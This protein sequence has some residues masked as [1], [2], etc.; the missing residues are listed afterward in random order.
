MTN[1]EDLEVKE[2]KDGRGGA[3]PGAGRKTNASK[4]LPPARQKCSPT[5]FPGTKDLAIL[6]AEME[7]FRGWGH[8]MDVAILKMAMELG[9]NVPFN[10]DQILNHSKVAETDG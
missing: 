3:R 8:V 1:I 4:G 5:L 10:T 7:G 2:K 9:I 6:I